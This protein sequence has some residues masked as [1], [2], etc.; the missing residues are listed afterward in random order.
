MDNAELIEAFHT[1][2][3]RYRAYTEDLLPRGG[4]IGVSFQC[5]SDRASRE[6]TQLLGFISC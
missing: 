1:Q 5:L 3:E 6:I 2:L 4:V